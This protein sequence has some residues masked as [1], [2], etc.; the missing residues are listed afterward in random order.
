[1]R[2]VF[3]GLALLT[4]AFAAGDQLARFIKR[5]LLGA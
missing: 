5:R 4:V 1:M 3:L 2:L